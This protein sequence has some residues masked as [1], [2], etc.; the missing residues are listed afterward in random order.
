M[1]TLSLLDGSGR[2]YPLED[3]AELT[4]G[5]APHCSVRLGALDVSRSHALLTCRRG[6]VIVLD[7]GSTNGTFVNG[8]RVKEGELVAGD[9]LRFSSVA[10][11]ILEASAGTPDEAGA[12]SAEREES[13]SGNV[14]ALLENSLHSLLTRWAVAGKSAQLALVDWLVTSRGVAG[15]AVLDNVDGVV[16][17]VAAEGQLTGVLEDPRCVQLVNGGDTGTVAPEGI[18]LTFGGRDALALRAHDSPWILLVPGQAMP[19]GGELALIVRLSA[20]ARRLDSAP[21]QR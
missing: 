21:S 18:H 13:T 19:D 14:P 15:A 1:L 6:K 12:E 16:G 4:V 5:A 11:Q 8:R 3:G 20:V 17:V 7:L 10:A 9:Q 2:D